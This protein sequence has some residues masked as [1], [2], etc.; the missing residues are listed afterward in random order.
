[1]STNIF[2]CADAFCDTQVIDI[3]VSKIMTIF[4]IKLHLWNVVHIL[5]HFQKGFLVLLNFVHL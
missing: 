2:F 1:L 5:C 4:F 3:K